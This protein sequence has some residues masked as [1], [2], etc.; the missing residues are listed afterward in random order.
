MIR[1]LF[2]YILVVLSGFVSID[3]GCAQDFM[4]H[5]LELDAPV[6]IDYSGYPVDIPIHIDGYEEITVI[7]AVFSWLAPRDI[8][9]V[10]ESWIGWRYINKID[11]CIY[12]SPPII[13]TGPQTVLSWD[14]S[15]ADQTRYPIDAYIVILA[16]PSEWSSQQVLPDVPFGYGGGALVTHD[17]EGN[18]FTTPFFIT[19]PEPGLD[20]GGNDVIYRRRIMIGV[21]DF[22]E[23]SWYPASSSWNAGRSFVQPPDSNGM[24]SFF[25]GGYSSEGGEIRKYRWIA[26][27]ESELI[28]GWG[29]GGVV[30]FSSDRLDI[31]V[32][33]PVDVGNG[34]L[35]MQQFFSDEETAGLVT[36]DMIDGTIIRSMDTGSWFAKI[37]SKSSFMPAEIS[38]NPSYYP[39]YPTSSPYLHRLLAFSHLEGLLLVIDPWH[40]SD[41]VSAA[42][43]LAGTPELT[44]GPSIWSDANG[45]IFYPY[46]SSEES[47]LGLLLNDVTCAGSIRFPD[48]SGSNGVLVAQFDSPYDGLYT[49]DSGTNSQRMVYYPFDTHHATIGHGP[50]R[51]DDSTPIPFKLS[52][53]HPNPF[54][55]V[56]TIPFS[57]PGEAAVTIDILNT[58]GAVVATLTDRVW[59]TGAHEI[60]WDA[61]DVASGLYF[62]RMRAAG[63]ADAMKMVVVK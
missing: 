1:R 60:K 35:V 44:L 50:Y 22:I 33:G 15:G 42:L 48:M 9:D 53:N 39:R 11:T 29:D 43:H 2:L 27:G 57:L 8:N 46:T 17:Y 24:F 28:T 20:G 45:W 51:V 14:G 10:N 32:S 58:A 19:V 30:R 34:Q 7:F 61:S 63:F 59:P 37:G 6:M 62:C 3:E 16:V 21:D 54:N 41:P 25:A 13:L 47:F 40:A 4:P 49:N 31:P 56:T 38:Y 55:P 36:V 26:D 18:P 5:K 12:V 52:P 23:T